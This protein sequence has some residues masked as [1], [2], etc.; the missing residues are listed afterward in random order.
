M[1]ALGNVD[2]AELTLAGMSTVKPK[3]TIVFM[4]GVRAS[5]PVSYINLF[6]NQLTIVGSYMYP[7]HAAQ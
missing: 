7:T 2:T 1:D 3:G 4:G 5:I 6:V